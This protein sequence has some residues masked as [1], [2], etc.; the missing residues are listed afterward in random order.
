MRYRA[1]R[2]FGKI[3]NMKL[4]SYNILY[5]G[6][7]RLDLI[8]RTIKIE[9]PDFL[10]INE[11]NDFEKNNNQKLNKFSEEIGLPNFKLALSG[12]HKYHTH[13]VV[14]SKHPF[15]EVKEIRPLRN[16][17]ILAVIETKLGEICVV[18]AHLSPYTEDSR[19]SE[20]DSILNQQKQYP[21]RILMGD[22]NSLSAGDDYNKEMIKAFNDTQLEKFTT[23]GKF[24]F[25]VINKIN[26]LGY[27]DAAVIFG[28][29]KEYTVPTKI[30][31]DEAHLINMRVDYIFVSDFLKNK[32]KNYSVIKNALTEKASDHYP[33]VIELE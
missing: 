32:V 15:K 17:G 9:N 4:I 18:G 21:N 26:S 19:L 22:M 16:A 11:A 20:I 2:L 3:K 7:D 24:R 31:Q 27:T 29:Q 12:E 23:D 25:D 5:G 33:V 6:G 10:V 13:T 14:F 28:K 1:G 30:N 8:I